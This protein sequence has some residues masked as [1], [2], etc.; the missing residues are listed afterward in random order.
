MPQ[1]QRNLQFWTPVQIS[2]ECFSSY[3]RHGL[4]KKFSQRMCCLALTSGNSQATNSQRAESSHNGENMEASGNHFSKGFPGT[5]SF[6]TVL[7]EKEG[8]PPGWA[9]W[10][11][12]AVSTP[13]LPVYTHCNPHT[14]FFPAAFKTEFWEPEQL[15]MLNVFQLDAPIKQEETQ[16]K[17]Y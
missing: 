10:K 16:I 15:Q 8:Q 7:L 9:M 2:P 12:G 6:D 14:A 4:L 11:M 3:C 17:T 5:L 13:G 1:H